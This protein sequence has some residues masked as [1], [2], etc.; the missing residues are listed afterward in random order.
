VAPWAAPKEV[1]VVS[2]LPRTPSGKIRR[3]DLM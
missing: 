2:K 3:A 1:E